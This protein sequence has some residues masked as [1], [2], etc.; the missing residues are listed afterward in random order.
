MGPVTR[1]R[2]VVAKEF[3]RVDHHAVLP[4]FEMHMAPVERPLEP[5]L[6]SS[7]PAGTRSHLPLQPRIVG[8]G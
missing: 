1:Q 2:V 3:A 8:G 5:A 6:A 7:C 4:D